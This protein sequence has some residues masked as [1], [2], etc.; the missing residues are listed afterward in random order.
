VLSLLVQELAARHSVDRVA[1]VAVAV[2]HTDIADQQ[3]AE[4]RLAHIAVEHQVEHTAV[5]QVD[6]TAKSTADQADRLAVGIEVDRYAWS[7]HT[8]KDCRTV[9]SQADAAYRSP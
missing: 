1:V 3:E 2:A 9:A 5:A 7:D 6:R 8:D 4:I